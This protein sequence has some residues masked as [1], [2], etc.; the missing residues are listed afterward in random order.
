MNSE[1]V[2]RK[3]GKKKIARI[4][5]I[6]QIRTAVESF[7]QKAGK[8]PS[9]LDFDKTDFLPTSRFIQRNYGGV[10]KLRALLGISISDYTKGEYRSGIAKVGIQRSNEYEDR[11]YSYLLSKIPEVR[12]HEHKI[13]RPGRI[14]CDFYIYT[15]SK[16]GIAVDLF[17]AQD[18]YSLSRI[19]TIKVKRYSKLKIGVFFVLIENS[20]ISQ[21]TIDKM[22]SNKKI[23]LPKNIKVL[24]EKHFERVVD[25]YTNQNSTS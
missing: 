24:T 14:C 8:Y 3:S 15:S 16:E 7:N 9:T 10:V 11:F 23:L 6:D 20:D 5:T 17:Y 25:K 19:I 4:W 2:Y 18:L 12:V 13:L 21:E 1:L 22:I